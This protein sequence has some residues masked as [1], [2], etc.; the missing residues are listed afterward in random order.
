MLWKKQNSSS[1]PNYCIWTWTK[2]SAFDDLLAVK[3]VLHRSLIQCKVWSISKLI[4]IL[5]NPDRNGLHL[6]QVLSH[7][8]ELTDLQQ[9]MTCVLNCLG[10]WYG[11]E[12]K[13]MSQYLSVCFSAFTS[14]PASCPQLHTTKKSFLVQDPLFG[15]CVYKDIIFEESVFSSV[16][17]LI[18]SFW[19]WPCRTQPDRFW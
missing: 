2:G 9:I 11:E 13:V 17:C 10:D 6:A 5:S 3:D 7:I 16:L 15:G 4:T 14:V 12:V 18:C 19:L 1:L 8:E